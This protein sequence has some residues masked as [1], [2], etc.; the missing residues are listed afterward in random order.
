MHW[1]LGCKKSSN[2]E[3][4]FHFYFLF[5]Y[6]FVIWDFE[7]IRLIHLLLLLTCERNP[8]CKD[9]DEKVFKCVRGGSFD[10]LF[11]C[12]SVWVCECVRRPQNKSNNCKS[13]RRACSLVLNETKYFLLKVDNY[14]TTKNWKSISSR[15]NRD[16]ELS[17]HSV[18]PEK[19]N[20]AKCWFTQSSRHTVFSFSDKMCSIQYYC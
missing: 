16:A 7:L 18:T 11:E 4:K 12:V 3:K 1:S 6:E 15:R 19:C 8:P 9:W 2:H 10:F 20:F 14:E 13:W 17:T 5:I